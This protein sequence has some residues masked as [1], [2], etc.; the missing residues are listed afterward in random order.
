MNRFERPGAKADRRVVVTGIGV[1]SPL[2]LTA[3]ETWK[4]TLE[5]VSGID[6]ITLFDASAFEVQIAGEVKNFNAEL[7]MQK[8]EVRRTDRFIHLSMA[9]SKMALQNSGF[10]I[11]ESNAERVGIF[12]GAGLGG[13][14]G[15]EEQHTILTTKSPTRVSPFF[16]PSVIANLAA[17]YF[18][19]ET[20][21]KGPNFCITSACATGAHS[22]GEAMN[23]IRRGTCDVMIAGG[24][25]CVVCP[26]AI[27]GFANMKALSSRNDA[28]QKASRPF[29]KDRD[30]FVLSEGAA[31]LIL[32]DYEHALKRGAKI[33]AEITG[34]GASADAYHITSPAP[35]HEGAQRAMKA[36]IKDARLNTTDIQYINAHGTSTP[37]G[38]ELEV[39][40]I[41]KTFGDYANKLAVSSTK[42]MTGHLLGA[43]GA[44]ESVFCILA[45]HNQVA[46]PTINLDNPSPD[47]DL[48]F[49]PHT[50]KE[51]KITNALNNS[52]GFGGTNACV[53]F[54]KLG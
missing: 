26:L 14:P 35:E 6:K 43:A 30:G 22:I 11:N 49:V 53:I 29:D 41:K 52:F 51:M 40:S 9:A 17:G 44:L 2:G 23:Y 27:A 5:G 19:I 16:I 24:T 45:I 38:D 7:Y 21:A 34:Y 46:P 36:A 1:V 37:I 4:N 10:Q 8:K 50:A 42:S 15:I 18:S 3:E 20:G 39:V 48:D 47:C 32:E 25:E 12:I 31:I 33:Y 54:S 13:L 28:P